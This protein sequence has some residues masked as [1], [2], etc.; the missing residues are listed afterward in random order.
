[1]PSAASMSPMMIATKTAITTPPQPQRNM[2]LPA[3]SGDAVRFHNGLWGSFEAWTTAYD[4]VAPEPHWGQLYNPL[5]TA[6]G[7]TRIGAVRIDHVFLMFGFFETG[8]R[9]VDDWTR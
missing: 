9:I 8:M 4:W 7:H 6:V 2:L 5:L 1:M 3:R